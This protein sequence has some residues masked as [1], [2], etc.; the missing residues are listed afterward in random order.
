[1]REFANELIIGR[2]NIEGSSL[3]VRLQL[4]DGLIIG[5]HNIEGSSLILSCR[6]SSAVLVSGAD[7]PSVR[8]SPVQSPVRCAS[9]SETT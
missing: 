4:E 8:C 3:I 5:R 6:G 1:M 2:H 9:N 7:G